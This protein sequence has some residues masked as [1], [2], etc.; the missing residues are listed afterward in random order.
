[1]LLASPEKS[2]SADKVCRELRSNVHSASNQL[3]Q[4]AHKGLLKT[5]EGDLYQYGPSSEELDRRVKTLYEFYKEM[6]V[7]VVTAIYEKPKD[8]LKDFSDAF[9]LKKD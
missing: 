7:A 5:T 6:P 8:R 2:F 9:K 3:S 4:L 1:M